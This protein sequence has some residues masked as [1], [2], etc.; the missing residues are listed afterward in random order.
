M[1]P[2]QQYSLILG[3]ISFT[4]SLSFPMITYVRFVCNGCFARP[5][6]CKKRHEHK[7]FVVVKSF[8]Q[9]NYVIDQTC[10][11]GNQCT[12]SFLSISN[13]NVRQIFQ[14]RWWGL[15]SELVY[16][17]CMADFN[18]ICQH[19]SRICLVFSVWFWTN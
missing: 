17:N 3:I 8:Q 2:Y 12:S 11:Q 13:D 15:I 14:F 9:S 1:L 7:A 6:F 18:Q 16:R 10:R 19:E 4:S 5:K